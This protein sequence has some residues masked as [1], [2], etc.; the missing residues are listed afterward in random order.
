[1]GYKYSSLLLVLADLVR[2]GRISLNE[3]DGLAEHKLRS[4]RDQA[5]VGA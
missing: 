5:K 2:E 1:M 4:I 3:V